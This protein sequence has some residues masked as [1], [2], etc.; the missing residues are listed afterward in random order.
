VDV[1]SDSGSDSELD[2]G[3]W[4]AGEAIDWS[5]DAMS[6]EEAAS[7]RVDDLQQRTVSFGSCAPCR[8]SALSL[9]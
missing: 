2:E 4:V 6:W 9:P 1:L 8:E 5:T 3:D 7:A